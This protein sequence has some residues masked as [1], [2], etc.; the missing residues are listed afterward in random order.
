[1][2]QLYAHEAGHKVA[3]SAAKYAGFFD[4]R[5]AAMASDVYLLLLLLAHFPLLFHLTPELPFLLLSFFEIVL[6]LNFDHIFVFFLVELLPELVY[7]TIVVFEELLLDCPELDLDLRLFFPQ[8]RYEE[9]MLPYLDPQFQL[10]MVLYCLENVLSGE[11][12]HWIFRFY[13]NAFEVYDSVADN[14]LCKSIH[15][16]KT[17]FQ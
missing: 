11:V 6:I 8:Q 3:L 12:P 15:P 2:E 13:D 16:S 14:L 9:G 1:M 7:R 4:E 5:V 10:Q 17:L